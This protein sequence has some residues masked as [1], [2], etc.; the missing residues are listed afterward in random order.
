MLSICIYG[1]TL[2]R[3]LLQEQWLKQGHT[4]VE[5]WKK[6]FENQK[7]CAF[8]NLMV[9]LLISKFD[10]PSLLIF[11]RVA[12]ENYFRGWEFSFLARLQLMRICFSIIF[13]EQSLI[14]W[15]VN[16]QKISTC[17][18]TQNRLPRCCGPQNLKK[19]I[20]Y[21]F[22]KKFLLEFDPCMADLKVVSLLV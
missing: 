22:W 4:W 9:P 17:P 13:L 14:R 19:I 2:H 11:P 7:Y 6:I 15:F 1:M 8:C 12:T 5:F 21:N 10:L 20:T 3:Q 18:I 16:F